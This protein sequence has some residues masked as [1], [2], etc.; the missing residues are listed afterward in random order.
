VSFKLAQVARGDALQAARFECPSGKTP[1]ESKADARAHWQ[2]IAAGE[3]RHRTPMRPL[4]C[5]WCGKYHLGHAR[6]TVY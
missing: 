5:G 3:N 1:Y 6:G 2:R 4:R